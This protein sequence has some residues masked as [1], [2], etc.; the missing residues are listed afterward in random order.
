MLENV[1]ESHQLRW[2][3]YNYFKCKVTI[4]LVPTNKDKYLNIFQVPKN[5]DKDKYL[6]IVTG[7]GGITFSNET[8]IKVSSKSLII[9]IQ[10]DKSIY[11]PGQLGKLV[12]R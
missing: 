9:L 7:S 3:I 6:L 2:Y 8:V 5:L 4:F 11:K 1:K 12:C 10:M